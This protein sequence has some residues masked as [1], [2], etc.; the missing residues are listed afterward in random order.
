VHRLFNSGYIPYSIFEK[1][2]ELRAVIG[3]LRDGYFSHGDIQLFKPLCDHLLFS[4]DYFVLADYDSYLEAQE[5]VNRTWLNP[6]RWTRMAI[7]NTARMG[8]FSS[9]RSIE[10]YCNIIWQVKP[11]EVNIHSLT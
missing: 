6:S 1:N 7:V 8:Y 9:D 5:R 10:E 3:L 4:D 2:E 11:L